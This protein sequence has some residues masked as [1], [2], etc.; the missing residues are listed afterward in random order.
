MFGRPYEHAEIEA[1]SLSRILRSRHEPH[2]YWATVG[3]V[4]AVLGT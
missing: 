2:R 1:L 3:E 4:A